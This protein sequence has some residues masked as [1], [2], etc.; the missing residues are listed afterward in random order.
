MSSR[1][2][3]LLPTD[4]ASPY[5][6]PVGGQLLPGTCTPILPSLLEAC[7][8]LFSS[9]IIAYLTERLTGAPGIPAAL[10]WIAAVTE[11]ISG[12]RKFTW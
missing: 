7:S 4:L 11:P 3:T 2:S 12:T 10:I 8:H 5:S 9:E 1:N 6:A